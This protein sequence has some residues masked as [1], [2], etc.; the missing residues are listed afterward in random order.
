MSETEVTL[1]TGKYTIST[2]VTK[3]ITISKDATV[4]ISI[5]EN[6]TPT[7]TAGKH[8]ITNNGTL[9]ITGSGTVDNVSHDV[10]HLLTSQ[11]RRLR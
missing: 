5:P 2:S 3:S 11:E 7:N 1:L 10:V 6:V 4:E 9:T 8:T